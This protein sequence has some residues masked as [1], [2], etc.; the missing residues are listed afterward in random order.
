MNLAVPPT[1]FAT[2]NRIGLLAGDAD[3]FPNG[4]RLVDDIVDIE[5]RAVAGVLRPRRSGCRRPT[6]P[7]RPSCRCSATA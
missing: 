5:E 4:R 6:A 2:Q 7:T 1:P 3:G